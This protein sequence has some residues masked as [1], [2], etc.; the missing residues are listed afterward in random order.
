MW[1]VVAI[2]AAKARAAQLGIELDV[3]DGGNKV[4]QQL[5][6]FDNAWLPSPTPLS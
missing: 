2:K 5:Q 3:F 6:Q 4:E 1:Y